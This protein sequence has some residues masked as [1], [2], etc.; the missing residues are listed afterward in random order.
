MDVFHHRLLTLFYRAWAEARPE[1]SHDRIDDDYWSA[2]LAALSGR[3]M[4]SLRGASRWRT[5][6]ATTTPATSPRR[7]ATRT[8]CG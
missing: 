2:R 6:H 1:I 3:G 4:P 8:A 5:P 7:P